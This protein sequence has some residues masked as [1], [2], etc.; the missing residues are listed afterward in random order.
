MARLDAL[1]FHL[2]GIGRDDAAYILDSF[3]IVREEDEK[4]FGSYLTKNSV[5]A[6]FSGAPSMRKQSYRS[7][8]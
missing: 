1:F 3:P 6:Y 5:L 2:C 7:Q 8:R 4:A